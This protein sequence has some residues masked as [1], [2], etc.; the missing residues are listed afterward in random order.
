MFFLEVVEVFFSFSLRAELCIFAGVF[1]LGRQEK[2]Q[3][4]C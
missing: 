2:T 4:V 3:A 1:V